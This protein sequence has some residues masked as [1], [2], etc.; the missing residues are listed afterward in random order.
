MPEDTIRKSAAFKK[1]KGWTL[2]ELGSMNGWSTS[3]MMEKFLDT[4]I[5]RMELEGLERHP[6]NIRHTTPKGI[7][8]MKCGAHRW[9]ATERYLGEFWRTPVVG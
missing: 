1:D 9:D 7:E 8:I 2:E 6:S 4:K 3:I 5:E